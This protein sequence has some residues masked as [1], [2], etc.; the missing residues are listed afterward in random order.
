MQARIVLLEGECRSFDNVKLNLM[1]RIKMLEYALR[2]E[3]YEATD[4]SPQ[5]EPESDVSWLQLK[6][7]RPARST[8]HPAHEA[9]HAA[10]RSG[11]PLTERWCEQWQLTGERRYVSAVSCDRGLF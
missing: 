9:R 1:R 2:V 3:R 4:S 7:A 8:V 6:A 5:H 10:V 11:P